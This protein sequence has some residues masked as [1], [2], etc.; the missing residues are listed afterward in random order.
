M[1]PDFN[2]VNIILQRIK[3]CRKKIGKIITLNSKML[4]FSGL[5]GLMFAMGFSI[6]SVSTVY[7]L[8]LRKELGLILVFFSFL[9]FVL[10]LAIFESFLKKQFKKINSE[11]KEI[12]EFPIGTIEVKEEIKV[13]LL[14]MIMTLEILF[15]NVEILASMLMGEINISSSGKIGSASE[16]ILVPFIVSTFIGTIVFILIPQVPI[17]FSE[18]LTNLIIN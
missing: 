13:Q 3:E 6:I 2:R 1:K 15:S 4:I 11:M 8:E 9:S 18:I 16:G 7:D 17:F 12:R 5:L 14:E 10:M